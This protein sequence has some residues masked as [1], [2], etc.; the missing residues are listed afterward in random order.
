MFLYRA[1]FTTALLLAL[2][3]LA[4]PLA[5]GGG[6]DDEEDDG[7]GAVAEKKLPSYSPPSPDKL[8]SIKGTINYTG[9]PPQVGTIPMDADANCV[10]ANPEAKA[11]DMIVNGDKVQY[12]F[13]FIKDGKFA[14]GNKSVKGFSYDAP[15]EAQTLDQ[16]GCMYRP[17]VLGVQ[18]KQ[19]I[20]ITNSD[21]TTH[22][23]NVQASKNEKINP[24]QPPGTGAIEHAFN[25]EEVL[26]PVKCNQHPWMKA[27]VG[28][29]PHP[30][31]AV[32]GE[33]GSFEI[34]NLPPGTYTVEVWHEKMKTQPQTVTVG[35]GE[36]KS[37]VNFTF[38]A[39]TASNELDGGSLTV[40][41]ALE[42]PL[43]GSKK[44]H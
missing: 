34:K 12:A 17:R 44:H 13:V 36:S 32:S 1:R 29:L 8:G 42:V 6:G 33:D 3:L 5:C 20:L 18:T 30:F 26:V 2:C 10:R 25:R 31:Y 27:Y 41:P 11:E 22:N 28:V 40:M 4:L 35:P 38:N 7:G 19:K 21:Q 16:S 24:S 14:D 37:G 23:V 43:I 9:A 15:A 39:A